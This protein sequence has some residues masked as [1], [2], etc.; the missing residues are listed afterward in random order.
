[1]TSRTYSR[2][3][4]CTPCANILSQTSCLTDRRR[5]A[6]AS[7]AAGDGERE[8]AFAL[9]AAGDGE[10]E[11]AFA[12]DADFVDLRGAGDGLRDWEVFLAAGEGFAEGFAG[13]GS[14]TPS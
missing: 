8:A 4:G 2:L 3:A 1:M 14:G 9:G 5:L 7:A 6:F 12:L 13:D 10:R 11:A